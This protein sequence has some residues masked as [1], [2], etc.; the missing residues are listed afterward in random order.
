ME[1]SLE[2]IDKAAA[3]VIASAK[4]DNLL[5]DAP[6]GSGKTT[7]IAAI[8]KQLGVTENISSP[9][10]NIVNQYQGNNYRIYHFDLYRIESIDELHDI[11][12]EEYFDEKSLRLIEWPSLIIPIISD[13]QH[14][15]IDIIGKDLRS[16]NVND[17]VRR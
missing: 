1:Y 13:Y 16:L 17:V 5:F 7:L 10:Y 9:T 6:M 15:K 2:E 3:Y 14:I 4:S 12:V 8:C 11:G